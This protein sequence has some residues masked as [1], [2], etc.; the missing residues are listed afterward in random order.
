MRRQFLVSLTASL[1][2]IAGAVSAAPASAVPASS[3]DIEVLTQ[4]QYVGADLIGVVSAPD[5]NAGVVEFLRVRAA[6]LPAE[7]TK[8][9]AALIEKRAPAL[10]GLQEVYQFSC[11]EP[12][13]KPDDQLGCEDPS[14]AGAFTDQLTDTLSALDGDYVEAATVV[15]VDLPKQLDLPPPLDLLPGLPINMNGIGILVRVVDR[16]VILARKDVAFQKIDFTQLQFIDAAICELKSADGCNYHEVASQDLT[17]PIPF[18]PYSLTR[19]VR[20]ERGFVGVD[21]SVAGKPYRFV[22]T[23]LETRLESFGP[24]GRYYQTAQAFELHSILGA[25]QAYSP[26]PKQIVVGDFNSDP[27]DV[28][29]VPGIIPPYQIFAA[30]HTD[31]WTK[32]PGAAT[33]KG[34]PLVGFS[35]CQAEDLAN[36]KSELYERID[37]IWSLAEPKKVQDARLLGESVSDKTPPIAIGVWP[38]DHAS[39]AAKLQY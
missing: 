11:F 31:V 15:N 39:V 18:P 28:E 19:T 20:F 8:A 26:A 36:H 25:L 2:G 3:G 29:D 33:G 7:R 13:P 38:S 22:T 27:R 24:L 17:L 1:L 21:A 16:D 14:I 5:F 37:L 6:S 12:D 4:N 32:R 30:D 10:V 9:L 35:C 23:H 34:A